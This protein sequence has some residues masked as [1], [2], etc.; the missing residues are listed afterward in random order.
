MR[1][2][3]MK[4]GLRKLI[5]L[6]VLLACVVFSG[7]SKPTGDD[8]VG[9]WMGI[10]DSRNNYSVYQY[11]IAA[12]QNG[13]DYVVRVTQYHYDITSV[14]G[15]AVWTATQPHYFRAVI[16]QNGDLMSDIGKIV[17]DPANFRLKYGDINLIRRSKNTEAKLKF[18]ARSNLE[19]QYADMK[20]ND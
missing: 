8:Y 18:V 4:S 14:E 17:A 19:K 3:E 10:D 15:L 11:D 6:P 9:T 7:C 13:R 1:F 2:A 12:N 16:D 5:L 20:F